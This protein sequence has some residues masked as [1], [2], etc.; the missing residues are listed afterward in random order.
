MK[1]I[2]KMKI[3]ID[4]K[5]FEVIPSVQYD[6]NTRFLHINLLN[7]SVPFNLTGCSVKISGTKPDGT[8]IFNNC[9]IINK[10]EGFIEVELTEQMNAVSG[11][12]KCEI[13]IYDGNGVLTTKQF[14]IEVTASVTSKEITS[15]NE[16]KA[17]EEALSKVQNID[18]KVG[19]KV[20][21]ESIEI[22]P[23]EGGGSNYVHP[24]T[25]PASMIT[26]L[27]QVATSGKFEDL[28]G[29]PTKLSEFQNDIGFGTGSGGSSSIAIKN[30]LDNYSG[31]TLGAKMIA[32]FA[33]I[34]KNHKNTPMLIT[35]PDGIIEINSNLRAV[36]W[37]NKIFIGN[38]YLYYNN[39]DAI[40][41][42]KCKHCKFY[43][44]ASSSSP[45]DIANNTLGLISPSQVKD[46][47]KR[48]YKITDCCYNDFTFNNIIGFTN[49]IEF[50]SE[51]GREGTFYNNIYFTAIWRCQ[52]PM[53]FKTGKAD[54][55]SKQSGWITEIFVHGGMFDCDDGILIG[56][57]L[58]DRPAG[59]PSDNYQGLKFY[60]LGIEHVRKKEKGIGIYFLQGRNNAVINPRFEG[61]LG[62]GNDTSGA[63]ILVK[64]SGDA[65]NNR[66]ET[67]NYP[68]NIGRVQLN[69]AEKQFAKQTYDNHA[70]SYIEGDLYHRREENGKILDFKLGYKAIATPGKMVY[71]ARNLSDYYLNRALPNTFNYTYGATEFAKIKVAEGVIKK[72]GYIN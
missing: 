4:K 55:T 3:D 42:V 25:H 16:F 43:I 38:T 57:E 54:D 34:N 9:T 65:C 37:T 35:L 6:S 53:K 5:N 49:G 51:Y 1:H 33:D 62:E 32:M 26:G 69:Y 27:S 36:G 52:R 29:R 8:A 60:N 63:Y 45:L 22:P 30:T 39:C 18:G 44:H 46:L 15:S 61:S 71:E 70:G 31:S 50:Y 2:K 72:I 48:G 10:R 17:L 41:F 12:V 20:V 64:E 47:T 58:N 66:I 19:F 40:E 21:G 13:K 23:I 14:Y 59:E 68:I 7:G 11:V 67:S 24:A 28:I 56:Q